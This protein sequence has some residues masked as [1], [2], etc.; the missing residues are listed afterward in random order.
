MRAHASH[1]ERDATSTLTDSA[2]PWP[3]PAAAPGSQASDRARPCPAGHD[4]IAS[5]HEPVASRPRLSERAA[6]RCGK[7]WRAVRARED[8][9]PA[10]ARGARPRS[11]V[12]P[13]EGVGRAPVR[14]NTGL[15]GTADCLDSGQILRHPMGGFGGLDSSR[16]RGSRATSARSRSSR[17]RYPLAAVLIERIEVPPAQPPCG[18]APPPGRTWVSPGTSRTR[19]TPRS[20]A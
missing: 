10:R 16:C 8:R 18:A 13:A 7:E 1:A 15:V 5:R 9:V 14:R 17:T 2:H 12:P 20:A 11:P 3:R 4:L 19:S 6:G